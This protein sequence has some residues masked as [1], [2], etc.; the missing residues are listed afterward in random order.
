[1][2]EA[3][4]KFRCNRGLQCFSILPPEIAS[5]LMSITSAQPDKPSATPPH[6]LQG[7]VLSILLAAGWTL[8]ALLAGRPVQKMPKICSL[9]HHLG[10]DLKLVE[11]KSIS[12]SPARLY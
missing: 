12:S 4:V 10:S 2:E 6:K 8:A 1:M 7:W 11:L 9:C 3:E 5:V